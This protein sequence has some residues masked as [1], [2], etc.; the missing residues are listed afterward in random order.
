MI[1]RCGETHM[2]I[3][4]IILHPF[5]N[6]VLHAPAMIDYKSPTCINYGCD[7][8]CAPVGN[9]YRPH[10]WKC[11]KA[12]YGDGT[13]AEGVTPWKTGIC[14]NHDGHLGFPCPMDY[15][16]AP[17]ARRTSTT[18]ID[19]K[20]GDKTNNDPSNLQ[21]LCQCCHKEKGRQAGDF[22]RQTRYK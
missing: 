14:S 9:R 17:W 11:H 5:K 7:K 6:I 13:L 20:D 1:Q 8:L 3:L 15:D 18:E 4:K 12:G 19:H 16:K 10:C 2:I 22:K 21:E